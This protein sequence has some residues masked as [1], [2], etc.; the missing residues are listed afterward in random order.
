MYCN[1][2]GAKVDLDSNYCEAC[3]HKLNTKVTSDDTTNEIIKEEIKK[4]ERLKEKK[5]IE[6]EKVV[7]KKRMPINLL[8]SL[9]LIII[10][11]SVLLYLAGKQIDDLNTAPAIKD[12]DTLSNSTGK[13]EYTIEVSYDFSFGVKLGSSTESS[14]TVRDENDNEVKVNFM[15]DFDTVYVMAP[16]QGY[17]EGMLYKISIKNGQFLNETYNKYNDVCFTI[18]K[19]TSSDQEVIEED[20]VIGTYTY[21]ENTIVLNKD[22]TFIMTYLDHDS[23]STIQ[24]TYKVENFVLILI[25]DEITYSFNIN[26]NKEISSLD[27]IGDSPYNEIGTVYTYKG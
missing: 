3:G 27:V 10:A 4:K 23:K 13:C 9:V 1:N 16:D 22:N 8:V 18:K 11:L 15:T 12:T 19:Q 14:V 7:V 5:V 25:S 17:Q 20:F 24:G 21:N 26:S 6:K 2:C